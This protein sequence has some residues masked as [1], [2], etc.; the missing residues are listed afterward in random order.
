MSYE[1]S[2]SRVEFLAIRRQPELDSWQRQASFT[3]VVTSGVAV[4]SI[5]P[6]KL[7]KLNSMA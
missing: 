6:T 3:P 5:E 4:A 7:T 2:V 1:S